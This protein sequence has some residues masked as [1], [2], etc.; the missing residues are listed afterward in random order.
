MK[1]AKEGLFYTL[2]LLA[3]HVCAARSGGSRGLG[4]A[5]KILNESGM[6]IAVYWI[7]PNTRDASPMTDSDGVVNGAEFP[8]DSYVGHEFELRELNCE[9]SANKSCRQ[10]FFKVSENDEQLAKLSAD[11]T[12]E[13]VDNKI[14]SQMQ[15]GDLIKECEAAAKAKIAASPES[16]SAAMDELLK[17]VEAGVT[18]ALEAVNEEIAFQASVRKDIA[19]ML[20]NYTC[21]DDTLNST[22]DISTSTWVDPKDTSTSHLVHIKHDRA[23]SRIHVIENFIRDD[24]CAA[25]ARA[26][27]KDL[28]RAT[29]ADGKGGSRLSENRKAMQAGIKVPWNKPFHP[30]SRVSRRVY[31][32]VNH[33]LGLNIQHNGQEDLVSEIV[34]PVN[35]RSYLLA[36]WHL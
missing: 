29:V 27:E 32:Y 33:V 2:M 6:R 19:A 34:F 25:M 15:A 11:F 14:K 12:I 20:E 4:R 10:A 31:D 17:C 35:F 1:K 7:H 24:E 22:A 36:P 18:S 26:A 9:S 8:L 21:V 16:T 30:I 13:F 23:A 28:H 3:L 5:I